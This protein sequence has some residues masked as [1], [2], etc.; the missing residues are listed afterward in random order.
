MTARTHLQVR[1]DEVVRD[2]QH[3]HRARDRR[4]ECEDAL[5]RDAATAGHRFDLV[6]ERALVALH[7]EARLEQSVVLANPKHAAHAFAAHREPQVKPVLLPEHRHRARIGEVADHLDGDDVVVAAEVRE[8]D[9][10]E[11]AAP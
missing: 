6:E 10:A 7:D 9:R 11:A 8:E 3:R 5:H 1:D 4:A 2:V